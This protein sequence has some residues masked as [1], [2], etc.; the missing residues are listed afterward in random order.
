M[1][2]GPFY[3]PFLRN[4]PTITLP[5]RA[6][7]LI[8]VVGSICDVYSVIMRRARLRDCNTSICQC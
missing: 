6:S 1:H 3:I 7:S 8:L 2:R 5:P 4:I